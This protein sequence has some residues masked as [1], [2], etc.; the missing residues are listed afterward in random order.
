M[1]QFLKTGRARRLGRTI[2]T[3]LISITMLAGSLSYAIPAR[4]EAAMKKDIKIQKAAPEDVCSIT[5]NG[6]DI[7]KDNVNGL[8]YKGFGFLSAN[9]TSD[10]LLDYKAEHPEAY[11]KL[12]QYLFGGD[13]PL[14]THV[15]LE[16]GNDRNTSTG[17]EAATM[18][19]PNEEV[20][21]LRNPGWQ[22]AADAKRINPKVKVSILRWCPPE[23]V[24]TDENIYTWYK[25]SILKAYE[26]YGY[27]VDY[28]NP[29]T[30]ES[31]KNSDYTTTKKFKKWILAENEKTIRDAKTRK[32]YQKIGLIV[33]DEAEQLDE[34]VYKT[35]TTDAEFR[36]AVSVAGYHYP[37][38]DNTNGGMKVLADELDM[39][40]WSSEN[41][42]TFS[43]SYFRP[44][45]TQ[46]DGDSTGIGGTGSALEMG[47]YIVK[48]FTESR[49]THIVY[50]PAVGSFYEGG[51]YSFKELVSARDPWSGFMHYDTGLLILS[52]LSRFAVTGWENESNTAGI[53]RAVTTASGCTV[54]GERNVEGR[55][56]GDSYLTLAAPDKTA[57]TT[58][59]VND[60]KHEKNYRIK[61][62][63][64]KLSS[65][66][67]QVWETRAADDGAYDENYMK[68]LNESLSK[69]SDG[70]YHIKVKPW[71]VVTVTS[72]D[73]KDASELKEGLPKDGER[74]VLDTDS[75]GGRQDTDSEYLYAD[76]FD[77]TGKTVPV[78]D[79][80]GGFTGEKE[81]YIASRGGDTG[82]MA[83]YVNNINGCFEV[84]KRP[85]GEY[86]LRQQLDQGVTG[87]GN[88]W[89]QGDPAAAIGDF[90]WTNYVASVDVLFEETTLAEPYASIAIRQTGGATKLFLTA[91]YTFEVNAKGAWKLYRKATST[92]KALLQEGQITDEKIFAT[93]FH[94][95]NNLCLEGAGNVIRAYVNGNLITSYED[96][97]PVTFGRIGLGSGF[98]YTEFDNLKVTKLKGEVPYYTELIDNMEI[99]DLTAEKNPKLVY[100]G[101]WSHE[102]GQGMYVYQRTKSFAQAKGDS[103]TYTFT[104]TG[105]EIIGSSKADIPL[106]VTVDGIPV[107]GEQKT[108]ETS[109]LG[110]SYRL[111]GLEPGQ[112]TVT[113]VSQ[114]ES[115]RLN[116]DMI[117]ILGNPAEKGE[118]AE[119]IKPVE[120]VQMAA[121]PK[122]AP[123]SS[124]AVDDTPAVTA[125]KKGDVI[126]SGGA[127][128]K[129][130]DA[131]GKTVT[132][133]KPVKK[134][135]T[136]VI[137]PATVK[138]TGTDGTATAFKVTAVAA[139]AC[140]GYKK[141][142]TVTIGK[143]IKTI[144]KNAFSGCIKLKK[145]KIS[146]TALKSVGKN[147]MKGI[148]K[149]AVITCKKSKKK[150]Y[151]KLFTKKTGFKKTMK[152]KAAS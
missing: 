49:R 43:N 5:I 97:A 79:G 110:T 15:K 93:G 142:K 118:T 116:I 58:L 36:N 132:Y 94:V 59:L 122:I 56:G 44:A 136:S 35:L 75:T 95:K 90:R 112:H 32:L 22:I 65:D 8:T 105:L 133:Q 30:N 53:W 62:E 67:L 102:C 41:Q 130:T 3:A 69:A 64:M 113:V 103:F 140:K 145:I 38:K 78:L 143:N 17:S 1:K 50:Q 68:L 114:G 26:T 144:G 111:T 34:N 24:K 99:Y 148:Y 46:S 20:N 107:E 83:R 23:W 55:D 6:N 66:E 91:G 12:M 57:F 115:S 85:D 7:K 16:M 86:V 19:Y 96:A 135:V 119:D 89:G 27:M 127:K 128:Y 87:T 108:V 106:E 52:H 150:A 152:L 147:A 39:E 125:L 31:W 149:K 60:S 45:N 131:S 37:N 47:N 51:Q 63:N 151:K 77:Y 117:G 18:R 139:G 40:V 54:G 11:A 13:Y 98:S 126:S 73:R 81:D 84:Y 104:G 109:D 61:T 82:A 14:M 33:T 28:I 92:K 138:L 124:E 71:S 100:E 80:K 21:I 48:G 141:L 101:K 137:I 70:T 134:T 123:G 25:R 146:T 76:N 2:G 121:V 9:S 74:T 88:A 129:I 4:T 42:A 29:N 120:P 72:L 10:L